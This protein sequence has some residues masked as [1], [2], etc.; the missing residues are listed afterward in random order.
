MFLQGL[1]TWMVAVYLD[2]W[3]FQKVLWKVLCRCQHLQLQRYQFPP[4]THGL[5]SMPSW[6][7][8]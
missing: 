1:L 7:R 5:V 3:G 6:S 8:L 4:C 2:G